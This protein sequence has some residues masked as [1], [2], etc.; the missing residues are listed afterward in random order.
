MSMWSYLSASRNDCYVMDEEFF[1]VEQ[2]KE[3]L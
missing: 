1:T 3:N 2:K